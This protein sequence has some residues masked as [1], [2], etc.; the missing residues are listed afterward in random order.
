MLDTGFCAI[1][2]WYMELRMSSPQ[3]SDLLRSELIREHFVSAPQQAR[4]EVGI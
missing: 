3:E 2:M 4:Q 1:T